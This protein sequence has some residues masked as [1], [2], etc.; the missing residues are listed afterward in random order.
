MKPIVQGLLEND[1]RVLAPVSTSF[2]HP[3]PAFS[4]AIRAQFAVARSSGYGP[5][6]SHWPTATRAQM[7]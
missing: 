2:G 7:F 5:R 1:D 6:V 3:Y 4:A